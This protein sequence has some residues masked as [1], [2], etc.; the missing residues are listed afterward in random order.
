LGF[1]PRFIDVKDLPEAVRTGA[2]DAQENPLTNTVNFHIHETH[3]HVTLTGHFY[4]VTLVLGNRARIEGWPK[5]ARDALIEA[6]AVAT[7]AQRGFAVEE[8]AA[9]LTVLTH[10]GAEV[11]VGEDLNRAAFVE[12]T[13][14]VAADLSATISED[15][16]SLARS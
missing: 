14:S 9:C 12:A 2:V 11:V 16:L 6:V 10:A 8:D 3:R 7:Q 4:G 13:A 15:V 1:E 5:R